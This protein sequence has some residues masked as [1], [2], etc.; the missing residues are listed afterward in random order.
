M[1]LAW[2][3]MQNHIFRTAGS[4]AAKNGERMERIF[5]DMSMG[6]SHFT[7]VVADWAARELAREHLGLVEVAPRPDRPYNI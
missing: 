1:T 7:N 3:S 4:S 2:D 5:R 6:W